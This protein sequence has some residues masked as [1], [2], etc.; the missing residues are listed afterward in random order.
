MQNMIFQVDQ[1]CKEAMRSNQDF[2][3]GFIKVR[4]KEDKQYVSKL[5]SQLSQGNEIR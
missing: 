5:E 3:E 4:G 1:D 2:W